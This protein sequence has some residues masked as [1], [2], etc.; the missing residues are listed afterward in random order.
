MIDV[1]RGRGLVR[2][3]VDASGDWDARLSDSELVLAPSRE[4]DEPDTVISADTA[5]WQ[6][7]ADDVRGGMRAFRAGRLHMRGSL[8]LGEG[9]LAATAG[10]DEPGRLAFERL[11]TRSGRVSILSAGSG[12]HTLLCLHGLG[13]TKASFLP[14][15]AAL[16]DGYRVVAMDLPGFGESDKPIGAPYNAAWFARTVFDTLD[17]LE[18]EG[19]T[20][21]G[22]SMGG[23]IAIE[24]GLTDPERVEGLV[25]L[26][27]ALAWL[28]DR[29]WT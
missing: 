19:A 22:N 29:R 1:P 28:R 3:R 17:A 18:V 16:A 7:I 21:V 14:T 5:T 6:S 23:R 25:L 24:A 15:V 12:S 9:L 2:L 26:S 11:R 4:G 13:A 8:H 27:P 20:L 10:S